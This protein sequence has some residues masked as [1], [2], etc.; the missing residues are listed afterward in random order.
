MKAAYNAVVADLN[1]RIRVLETARDAVLE[2]GGSE[3]R[4]V[5]LPFKFDRTGKRGKTKK[6]RAKAGGGD[7]VIL[8]VIRDGADTMKQIIA[9][10]KVKPYVA[11]MAVRRLVEAGSVVA[12]GATSTRRYAVAKK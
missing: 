4:P 12:T 9:D 11:T 10:A 7:D 3:D 6:G 5:K 1:A 2:A 8:G